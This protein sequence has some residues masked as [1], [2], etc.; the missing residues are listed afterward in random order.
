MTFAQQ[1]S[2]NEWAYSRDARA[3][4]PESFFLSPLSLF[5]ELG[6]VHEVGAAEARQVL[7][8]VH[9]AHYKV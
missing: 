2:G 5:G 4:K 3:K 8:D 1:L 7:G 6:L 9:E